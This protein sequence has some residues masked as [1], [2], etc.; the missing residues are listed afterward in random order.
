MKVMF[1]ATKNMEFTANVAEPNVLMGLPQDPGM[2]AV[3]PHCT[4]VLSA[5]APSTLTNA[6]IG[7]MFTFSL[8]IE[9]ST[10]LSAD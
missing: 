7:D 6:R 10:R 9:R 1:L 5:P 3:S 4:T 2:S 8:Q